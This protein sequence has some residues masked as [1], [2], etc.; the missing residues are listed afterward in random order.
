MSPLKLLLSL[1]RN[2]M[3]LFLLSLLITTS[4]FGM[5]C[6]ELPTPPGL[7][8]ILP[9]PC[10]IEA[11]SF[12]QMGSPLEDNG[13]FCQTD[14]ADAIGNLEENLRPKK[15]YK[16]QLSVSIISEVQKNLS[17]ITL[18]LLRLRN[19]VALDTDTNTASTSCDIDKK[20]LKPSCLA[21]DP[22]LS[23][24]FD[25]DVK[26]LKD[27]LATELSTFVLGTKS[28]AAGL[29]TK[30][31]IEQCG[32]TD[33]SVVFAQTRYSE[34]LLTPELIKVIDSFKI[35]DGQTL[36]KYLANNYQVKQ[37]H[38]ELNHLHLFSMHPLLRSIYSDKASLDAFLKETRNKKDS[39]E[40]R[41][42][43]YSKSSLNSFDIN[44]ATRCSNLFKDAS[45][46][47]DQIY[48]KESPRYIPT[49]QDSMQIIMGKKFSKLTPTSNDKNPA[50]SNLRNFCSMINN[51]VDLKHKDYQDKYVD[52]PLKDGAKPFSDIRDALNGK[53]DTASSKF[54]LEDFKEDL[55]RLQIGSTKD[56]M[57]NEAKECNKNS[58]DVACKLVELLNLSNKD[59]TLMAMKESSNRSINSII[60]ALAGTG[61]PQLNGKS[62][63]IALNNLREKGLLKSASGTESI[64]KDKNPV[65]FEK[66]S[67]ALKANGS[68]T[69]DIQD[70]GIDFSPNSEL[71]KV[72]SPT[73]NASASIYKKATIERNVET[74]TSV[75]K[76]VTKQPSISEKQIEEEVQNETL[77]YMMNAQRQ[78]GGKIE[79]P[80]ITGSLPVGEAKPMGPSLSASTDKKNVVSAPVTIPYVSSEN[81]FENKV[82][83]SPDDQSD[84]AKSAFNKALNQAQA[85]SGSNP[86]SP[87]LGGV[88]GGGES[89]AR[90]IA[91][92]PSAGTPNNS[93]TIETSTVEN[94][95][96]KAL[97]AEIGA[98]G[99]RAIEKVTIVKHKDRIV[100]NIEGSELIVVMKDG[101]FVALA[102]ERKGL[103]FVKAL[104]TYF[105]KAQAKMITLQNLKRTF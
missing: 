83:L 54:P 79:T 103:Q 20:L 87:G 91:S 34:S 100:V 61:Q 9:M 57:C 1:R 7:E 69:R 47:L 25:A 73:Q 78:S 3:K 43:I 40:I 62:D 4:S 10:V 80:S 98:T 49:E 22:V 12:N 46:F 74:Q 65:S 44:L 59:E 97:Q 70:S 81:G 17:F 8:P 5:N 85:G 31:K 90:S 66:Y 24:E 35:P 82:V 39:D 48:C 51:S 16:S 88:N 104:E 72:E 41:K 68:I 18:D 84:F 101:K 89:A 23:K 29:F 77:D 63:T 52:Y 50:Q 21:S 60:Q 95:I 58:T 32:Y 37:K 26:R 102:S 33:S 30:P 55:Y 92:V 2:K 42:S 96:K 14:C 93:L 86:N 56:L 53:N 38:P 6:G 28:S 15:E 64:S 11:S 76:P 105:N 71:N 13:R 36:E 67:R 94:E 75:A 27:S 99:T 45:S 19:T